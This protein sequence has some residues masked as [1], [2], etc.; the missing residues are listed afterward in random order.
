MVLEEARAAA[1]GLECYIWYC[2]V[3]PGMEWCGITG[4]AS[5]QQPGELPMIGSLWPLL[6]LGDGHWPAKNIYFHLYL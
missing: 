4:A 5:G 3:W 2:M 1:V 6:G